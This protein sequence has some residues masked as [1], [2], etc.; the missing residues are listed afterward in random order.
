MVKWRRQKAN[1]AEDNPAAIVIPGLGPV[2][3]MGL[4]DEDE[5]VSD[6]I[7]VPLLDT[8]F[9]FF[10]E[11]Y[12]ADDCPADFHAAIEAFLELDRSVLEAAADD[13]FA[14]YQ[15]IRA[16][17]E[18]RDGYDDEDSVPGIAGPDEI[19]DHIEVTDDATIAREPDGDREVCVSV[20]FDC[21]WERIRGLEIVFGGGRRVIRVGPAVA[22]T[23]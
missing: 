5:Y 6:P 12:D 9:E 14:Y 2:I 10:I 1:P 3:R 7:F 18:A 4:H 16:R 15:D 11:D 21:D 8:E 17:V 22:D 19:L 13:L 23:D 20:V